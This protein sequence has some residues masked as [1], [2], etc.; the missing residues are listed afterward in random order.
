[1]ER[2]RLYALPAS[3]AEKEK[4]NEINSQN[5]TA[6]LG[7]PDSWRDKDGYTFANELHIPVFKP[8]LEALYSETKEVYVM[9]EDYRQAWSEVH[10][11]FGIDQDDLLHAKGSAERSS[12]LYYDRD[13]NSLEHTP[14]LH[15]EYYSTESSLV[16]VFEKGH[17]P[18]LEAHTH[19]QDRLPS[20]EDYKGMLFDIG[21]NKKSPLVNGILIACP[22]MQLLA[23]RR[24]SSPLKDP[25]GLREYIFELENI[26]GYEA[27]YGLEDR[28]MERA[29][30]IFEKSMQRQGDTFDQTKR[31]LEEID[32]QLKEKTISEDEAR[33]ERR[34]LKA[35]TEEHLEWITEKMAELWA[36]NNLLYAPR[37]NR[38]LNLGSIELMRRLD[39]QLY[40]SEDME[41]FKA[42][43]A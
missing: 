9:S 34:L 39:M 30:V 22:T 38:A 26:D 42:F 25:K 43:T 13:K 4:T 12:V 10:E 24:Y 17:S 18:L 35:E 5:I 2:K 27:A 41:N 7:N 21:E 14:P 6:F 28:R 31:Y 3:I 33:N 1:M 15:G 8:V 36:L 20:P 23:L 16:K 11:R 29:L 32:S 37:I 40:I 19:P